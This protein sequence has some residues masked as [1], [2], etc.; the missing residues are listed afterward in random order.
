M[1]DIKSKSRGQNVPRCLLQVWAERYTDP[2][3]GKYLRRHALH[4]QRKAAEALLDHGAEDDPGLSANIAILTVLTL[5][6]GGALSALQPALLELAAESEREMLEWMQAV[7]TARLCVVDAEAAKLTEARRQ[8][9]ARVELCWWFSQS[10]EQYRFAGE[11]AYV[12]GD[13]EG[14]DAPE[15]SE[16]ASREEAIAFLGVQYKRFSEVQS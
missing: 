5:V 16:P 9:S 11:I 7:R 13:A 10:S 6:A 8:E 12:G 2:C 15:L 14:D 4:R 1:E 3:S